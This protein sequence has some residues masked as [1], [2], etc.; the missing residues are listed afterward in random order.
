IG[1]CKLQDVD[2]WEYL[3]DVLDRLLDHPANRVHELTPKNWKAM[4]QGH[5]LGI[6]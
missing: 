2:P 1:S 4:K 6:G 5:T 3:R